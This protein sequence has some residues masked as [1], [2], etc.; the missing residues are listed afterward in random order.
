MKNNKNLQITALFATAL[1]LIM[2]L[3]TLVF[4]SSR[5]NTDSI[6]IVSVLLICT[7]VI[8]LMYILLIVRRVNP[9]QYIYISYT[10]ADEE[11]ANLVSATL[12]EQL[13]KFSKYHY[14][15]LSADSVP[16]GSDMH[17]TVEEYLEKA[18]IVI[19][20]VSENYVTSSWCHREFISF[21][22]RNKKIIPI[23]VDSY[24]HLSKLPKDISNIKALSLREC[25]STDEF[26]RHITS[27]AKELVKQRQD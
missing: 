5:F 20:I 23:V 22:N 2:A 14:E 19:V 16:Y 21:S 18:A 9:K 4:D 6:L 12:E 11:T 13:N 15:I 10:S 17:K 3:F 8:S 27:L 25:S 7:V 24:G 26:K 1:S